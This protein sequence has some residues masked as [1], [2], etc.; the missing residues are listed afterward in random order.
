MPAQAAVD[1]AVRDL[2][3]QQR[4]RQSRVWHSA[5]GALPADLS[6][7][8]DTGREHLPETAGSAFPDVLDLLLARRAAQRNDS[9]AAER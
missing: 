2:G 5:L 1:A 6:P 8:L 7:N 9:G 3:D 4:H